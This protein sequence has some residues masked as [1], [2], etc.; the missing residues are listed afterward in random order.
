MKAH[1]IVDTEN[2]GQADAWTSN[3]QPNTNGSPN[4]YFTNAYAAIE[5]GEMGRGK[6]SLAKLEQ[7]EQNPERDIQIK[8]LKGLLKIE[9]GN[10]D[11]GINLLKEAV[12][13]E[14]EL[15][16]DFGPPTIV[17]PSAELLADVFMELE[18]P[19]MAK[20]Y[21]Q[22]QLERTPKRRLSLNGMQRAKQVAAK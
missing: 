7:T 17:K 6:E 12:T 11:E 10:T 13:A 18:K 8:Q 2:W 1:Q 21:Y 14:F 9:Q 15:P 4:Y 20:E 16:I 3:Y 5:N 19:G 22:K